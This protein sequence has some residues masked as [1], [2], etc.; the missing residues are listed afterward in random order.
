MKYGDLKLNL[1]SESFI[2]KPKQLAII[3][4]LQI[5]S[6]IKINKNSKDIFAIYLDK[7]WIERF[8]DNI[9]FSKNI[10][11]NTNLYNQFLQ[12]CENIF[13]DKSILEK[14]EL[15]INFIAKLYNKYKTKKTTTQ[16]NTLVKDIQNYIDNN[17]QNDLLINDISNEF[18][19]TSSHIIRIF[20]KELGMTPYQY[21]L[22]K[23]VNLAKE[24]LSQNISIT[25][26][27]LMCGFSDQSHLYKY[28]QQIFSITPKEYQKSILK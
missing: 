22:N 7:L 14:E 25:E 16:D 24:L 12:L 20:K 2:L 6:A 23:R 28:F 18:L 15:I 13:S 4:P 10:I 9:D 26:V 3:K 21:I 8:E 5:H 1:K 19:I 11:E 27:S 17:Y